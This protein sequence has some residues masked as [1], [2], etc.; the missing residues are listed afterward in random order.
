[1]DLTVRGLEN[2]IFDLYDGGFLRFHSSYVRGFRCLLELAID[3]CPSCSLAPFTVNML[4]ERQTRYPAQFE[5]SLDI[6][7]RSFSARPRLWKAF[8]L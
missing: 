3:P 6:E 5:I 4:Y 2:D 7:P 1:M 8:T